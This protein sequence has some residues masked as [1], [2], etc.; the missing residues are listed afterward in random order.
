MKAIIPRR[1]ETTIEI[2]ESSTLIIRQVDQGG[3]SHVIMFAIDDAERLAS[4]VRQ[5]V[6]KYRRP[7]FEDGKFTNGDLARNEIAL[8]DASKPLLKRKGST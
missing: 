8:P 5:L 6:E 3:E 4:E 7:F 1:D 2:D